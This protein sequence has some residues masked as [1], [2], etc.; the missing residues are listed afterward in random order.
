M[1]MAATTSG[2]GKISS[3][4]LRSHC[5]MARTMWE[6]TSRSSTSIGRICGRIIA[7]YLVLLALW[8]VTASWFGRRQVILRLVDR[9]GTS[10]HRRCSS[11]LDSTFWYVDLLRLR[12]TRLKG[13]SSQVGLWEVIVTTDD[14]R[15]ER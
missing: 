12:L 3:P 2:S 6:F 4:S 14:T 13:R 15:L 5:P 9:R 8:C 1:A 7:I 10:W 11:D